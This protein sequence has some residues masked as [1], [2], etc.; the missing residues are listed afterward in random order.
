MTELYLYKSDPLVARAREY[1]RRVH[2]E[3]NHRYDR[4]PYSYHLEMVAK[5]AAKYDNLLAAPHRATA[6][7][8]AYVHDCIEDARQTYNDVVKATNVEVAEIAYRLTNEKGRTRKDRANAAYYQGIR[9][10]WV[11]RFVKICDRLANVEYS[12][13]RESRMLSVYRLEFA[14]FY[15]ELGCPGFEPMFNEMVLMLKP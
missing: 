11:A 1:G 9:E 14:D 12:A 2:D 6:V 13:N 15:E 3:A 7:A 4:H 10:N 8:G 5:Y